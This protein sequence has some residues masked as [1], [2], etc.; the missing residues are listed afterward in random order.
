MKLYNKLD[1]C[2]AHKIVILPNNNVYVYED[3]EIFDDY[4]LMSKY[5]YPFTDII[6]L[7]MHLNKN[8]NIND[9]ING[10][11]DKYTS[12]TD[13]HYIELKCSREALFND[14]NE[15]EFAVNIVLGV[16][17]FNKLSKLGIRVTIERESIN[18]NTMSN[19]KI[20]YGKYSY[21]FNYHN[22]N[23]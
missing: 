23:R 1:D 7:D 5:N 4:T 10:M 14:R 21:D 20:L 6:I 19:E 9:I 3:N 18:I 15:V 11:R 17:N 16:L 2:K 13:I 12:N 8:I 22:Y